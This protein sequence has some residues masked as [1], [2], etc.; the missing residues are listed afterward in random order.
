MSEEKINGN[1]NAM[2]KELAK[3]IVSEIVLSGSPGRVIKKWREIFKISQKRLASIIGVTSSVVSDYESGRRKS[4]GVGVVKRFVNALIDIDVKGGGNVIRTL[5]RVAQTQHASEAIIDIREFPDGVSVTDFCKHINVDIVT[6][7][8]D[9]KREIY[10]YTVID[11]LKAITEFSFSELLKLYGT[12]TQ[13]ALIF[14]KVST[15][16]SPLVAL[17]M[18][19]LKPSLVVLHGLDVVNEIAIR[20]GEI[21]D[22]PIG[23]CRLEKIDDMVEKLKLIKV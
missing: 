16:K 19:N 22:I 14:T 2:K 3:D 23:V 4:P 11:S 17:K 5:G 6:T 7:G 18:T 1:F 10:G 8:L 21:E 13:R 12:T 15:G 20:I 9:L